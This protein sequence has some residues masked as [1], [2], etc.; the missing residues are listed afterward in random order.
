MSIDI[1]VCI[2][3]F[4]LGVMRD[5]LKFALILVHVAQIAT[6]NTLRQIVYKLSVVYIYVYF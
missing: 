2:Y 6:R 3:M 5:D 1:G 4:T